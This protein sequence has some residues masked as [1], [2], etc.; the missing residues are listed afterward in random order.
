MTACRVR[1]TR[2]TLET[3]AF[4]WVTFGEN[5]A[6]LASG[7]SN[8]R[9]PSVT[10][11][12]ELVL[13]SELV[14]LERV[15][16]PAAQQRQLSAALRFLVEESAISD[17]E[18]LHVAAAAGPG[19]DMLSVAIVDRPWL[20]QLL[21]RLERAGL[22]AR[23]AYPECL[24]PALEP[25]AWTVVCNGA[26]GFA[27]TAE[28]EGFALDDAPAGEPPIALRLAL[29]RV[30]ATASAPERIVVRAAADG[31]GPD[32]QRWPAALGVGV[33]RGPDWRWNQAQ[34]RPALE[35]L[36]GEFA[37]PGA[38]RDWRARLR[39][40]SLLAAA[41]ALLATCGIAI[42]WGVKAN[43]RKALLA[44]MQAIYRAT[45]GEKAVVADPPLQM[46][47]ALSELRREAG[48][49]DAGDFLV[50]LG[51]VADAPLDPARLQLES[52]SYAGGM[53]TLQLR[54]RDPAQLGVQMERLRARMPAPGLDV[55]VEATGAGAD[56]SVRLTA[57]PAGVP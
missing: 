3:G 8:L 6:A 55:R 44:E 50:L 53:L 33:E 46:R 40:S 20:E 30:R 57:R 13:A 36:Q 14:L 28:I 7:A 37:P 34:P 16:C 43:E 42:D 5:G 47:R 23:S 54:P 9:Q 52:I 19:K 26:S 25:H 10:G 17:P 45:H 48:L 2:D 1:V 32:T 56:A 41:L 24:L 49:L 15:A 39:R 51:A 4:E 31:V 27:R 18:R 38:G 29:E 21:S 12:C 11:E 35:L 22:S